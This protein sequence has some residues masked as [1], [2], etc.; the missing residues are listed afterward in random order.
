[1]FSKCHGMDLFAWQLAILLNLLKTGQDIAFLNNFVGQFDL[2]QLGGGD[3]R[4][5]V[6]QKLKSGD[7]RCLGAGIK[8]ELTP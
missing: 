5:C 1:M 3:R 2:F 6:L 8:S 7:R 4:I